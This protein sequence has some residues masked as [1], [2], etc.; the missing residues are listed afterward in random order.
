MTELKEI[1]KNFT[2][3]E[4]RRDSVRKKAKEA[5]TIIEEKR[6]AEA[7]KKR[8]EE[9][10]KLAEGGGRGPPTTGEKQFKQPTGVLPS[11][12]SSE[13]TPLLGQDWGNYTR[14]YVR[15]CSNSGRSR[16]H[17]STRI[18]IPEVLSRTQT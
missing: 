2:E 4:E 16:I 1:A 8:E 11:R 14:L 9:A 6:N 13:F 3:I 17:Q 10:K 12:I 5:N 7:V 18:E 15:G